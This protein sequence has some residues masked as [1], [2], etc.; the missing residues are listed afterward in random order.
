MKYGTGH[1]F[2]WSTNSVFIRVQSQVIDF[3]DIRWFIYV[4]FIAD[5][6]KPIDDFKPTP[7][8]FQY[9]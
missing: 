4:L 6:S 1:I 2:A 9:T 3:Y 5:T 7:N 8:Q